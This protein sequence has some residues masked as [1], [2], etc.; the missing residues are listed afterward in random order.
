MPC[1][2][3]RPATA[4]RSTILMVDD[5]AV[6]RD[7]LGR[8]LLAEGYQCVQAPNVVSALEYLN[9]HDIA[10]IT[11]DLR[12]PGDSGM[13]LLGHVKDKFPDTVVLMLTASGETANAIEALTKGAFAYLL[14]PVERAE[15]LFQVR[16]GLE[17]RQMLIEKRQY[18]AALERRV[19][20]QTVSIRQAHEETIHRL[21]I[22]T[23]CRDEETGAH[24]RRTGL[25]SEVLARAAGWSPTEADRIRTAAPMH[26]V[27]KIGIPDAILRKPGKLTAE[28]F[29]VMKTHTVLGAQMLDG[30][31]S[32][33][34]QM[35]RDIALNHHERWDGAG[36]PHGLMGEAIPE[37]ARILSIADVFDA[38]THDRVYRRALP[39][40]EV[41]AL[42]R[43]GQG[44]QFDPLL[45][46]LFFTALDR[47]DE[48]SAQHLDA[49]PAANEGPIVMAETS[50]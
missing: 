42:M 13:E 24:I 44:S 1:D 49:K 33:F 12:M 34:L 18:T 46:A 30:S 27:G 16:Q 10:L 45:L 2:V 50:F 8:W 9:T 20:E 7:I 48:I 29:E 6:V 23:M 37:C 41:L 25:F 39:E 43:Q 31:A 15:L 32:P 5:E 47:I 21:I 38:L 28:E 14:K 3:S 22:A 35:A 19:L 40:Q 17:H 36:Y 26:D 11:L 4:D